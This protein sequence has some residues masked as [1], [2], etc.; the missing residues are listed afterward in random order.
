MGRREEFLSCGV[1]D[2][3]PEGDLILKQSAIPKPGVPSLPSEDIFLVHAPLRDAAL[4]E[5]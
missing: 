1:E 3:L 2:G 5:E 4:L